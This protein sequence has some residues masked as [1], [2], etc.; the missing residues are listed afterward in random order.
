MTTELL[1]DGVWVD[2]SA[3]EIPAEPCGCTPRECDGCEIAEDARA[4]R[5]EDV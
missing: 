5:R 2:V 1:L 3:Y 4:K